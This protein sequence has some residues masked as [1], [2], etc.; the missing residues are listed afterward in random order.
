[1]SDWTQSADNRLSAG[2]SRSKSCASNGPATAAE[3]AS[4]EAAAVA[5]TNSRNCR[6]VA[7]GPQADEEQPQSW[8]IVRSDIFISCRRQGEA[9]FTA[10]GRITG[11]TIGQQ[12][13][14][15]KTPCRSRFP[16]QAIQY[17]P[18]TS[19]S[20]REARARSSWTSMV[21]ARKRT[22]PSH[23]STCAPPG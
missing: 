21:S 14:A 13:P 8:W 9:F 20:L 2:T 16:R 6:R 1:M 15:V 7:V 4:H 23:N 22:D 5:P 17:F 18:M 10:V 12:A 3:W 11:L 19:P